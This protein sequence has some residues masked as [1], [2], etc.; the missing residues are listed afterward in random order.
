[1]PSLKARYLAKRAA[2]AHRGHKDEPSTST[3]ESTAPEAKAKPELR[4][5]LKMVIDGEEVEIRD[6]IQLYATNEQLAYP[7]VLFHCSSSID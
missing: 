7:Y 2:K 3:E 5:G 1:M 4:E 6:Q